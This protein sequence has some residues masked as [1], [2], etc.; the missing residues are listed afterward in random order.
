MAVDKLVD[1]TQLDSDLTAVANAIRTKGG[2]SAQMA[3]PSGFVSAVQ[4]IPSGGG[5]GNGYALLASGEY[6]KTGA[7]S[8][9][10]SIPVS[11]S[12]TPVFVYVVANSII[13]DTN[14]SYAFIAILE[15][16]LPF[17]QFLQNGSTG[18]TSAVNTAG[19]LAANALN[20]ANTLSGGTIT[21]SRLSNTYLIQPN[22]YTWYIYGI[23]NGT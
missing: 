18:L 15:N 2:T 12:G 17:A 5:G 6:T 4:A 7:A 22:T 16:G 3:F 10:M 11:Y 13:P 19:A 23:A 14:Q 1:S 9:S 20:S 21:C 8:A